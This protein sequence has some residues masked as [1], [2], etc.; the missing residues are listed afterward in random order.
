MSEDMF[1][2]KLFIFLSAKISDLLKP[3]LLFQINLIARFASGMFTAS[4]EYAMQLFV[5]VVS[6][7]RVLY[8]HAVMEE[9]TCLFA[10]HTPQTAKIKQ[11]VYCR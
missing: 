8:W 1:I 3:L 9:I 7:I 4:W 6:N 2:I 11:R 10:V 5:V